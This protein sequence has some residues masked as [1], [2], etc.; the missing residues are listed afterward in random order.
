MHASGDLDF[1]GEI[2]FG[3]DGRRSFLSCGDYPSLRTLGVT[4]F[5]AVTGAK[6]G[7]FGVFGQ[8]EVARLQTFCELGDVSAHS[9]RQFMIYRGLSVAGYGVDANAV[10]LGVLADRRSHR[11]HDLVAA[12]GETDFE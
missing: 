2:A 4:A 9:E 10:G 7:R 1:L 3:F 5:L 6:L 8:A 11:D 12:L